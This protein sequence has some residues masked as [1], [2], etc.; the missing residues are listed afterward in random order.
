MGLLGNW[1]F[2]Y[3]ASK[4][5]RPQHGVIYLFIFVQPPKVLHCD[6]DMSHHMVLA[7]TYLTAI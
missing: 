1:M 3:I 4:P 5:P 7:E 2:I 6:H